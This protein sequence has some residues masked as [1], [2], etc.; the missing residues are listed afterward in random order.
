MAFAFAGVEVKSQG[1]N[2]ANPMGAPSC[3]RL[4]SQNRPHYRK[5][6]YESTSVAVSGGGT[7][8]ASKKLRFSCRVQLGAPSKINFALYALSYVVIAGKPIGSAELHSARFA[9]P[10]ALQEDLIREYIGGGISGGG[11]AS[12]ASKK[13]SLF[14]PSTT[15]RSQAVTST[16]RRSQ[17]YRRLLYALPYVARVVRRFL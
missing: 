17:Q 16:T 8:A 1:S 13:A 6:S 10:T 3:T 4:G 14:V 2:L 7:S 5:I 12:V 11:G 9:E 15:R